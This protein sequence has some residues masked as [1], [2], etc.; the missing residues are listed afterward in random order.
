MWQCSNES[1]GR[2]TQNLVRNYDPQKVLNRSE[3]SKVSLVLLHLE[4][5]NANRFQQLN[6]F[7]IIIPFVRWKK[8]K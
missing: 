3:I 1:A 6:I 4:W 8:I 2:I 7:K 5:A